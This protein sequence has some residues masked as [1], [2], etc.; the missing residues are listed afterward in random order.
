MVLDPQ[1]SIHDAPK[2][3][4]DTRMM[5][6]ELGAMEPP[7]AGVPGTSLATFK[8]HVFLLLLVLKDGGFCK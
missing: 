8:C 1:L 5:M 2:I 3:R 4:E 7:I 6:D